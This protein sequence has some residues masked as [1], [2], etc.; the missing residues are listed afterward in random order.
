MPD[1]KFWNRYGCTRE[2]S[3]NAAPHG[4]THSECPE[5]PRCHRRGRRQAYSS[6][7]LLSLSTGNRAGFSKDGAKGSRCKISQQ[8]SGT[9]STLALLP[10]LGTPDLLPTLLPA[11]GYRYWRIS[12]RLR[13]VAGLP[14]DSPVFP[15]RRLCFDWPA[16]GPA[17]RS[18]RVHKPTSRYQS[19]R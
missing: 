18:I 17:Q 13:L 9:R 1:G 16:I 5:A 2:R 8:R 7:P 15:G 4:G 6:Q 11:H 10:R 19:P 14:S 3:G 12:F